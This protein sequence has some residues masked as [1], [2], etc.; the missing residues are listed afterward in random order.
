MQPKEDFIESTLKRHLRSHALKTEDMSFFDDAVLKS[1][2]RINDFVQVVE[3]LTALAVMY[4]I[5]RGQEGHSLTK[6]NQGLK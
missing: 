6:K 1:P 2:I 4:T 5:T 3:S